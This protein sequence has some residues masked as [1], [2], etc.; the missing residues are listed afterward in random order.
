MGLTVFD[1]GVLIGFLDRR[2]GHHVEAR[3]AL[4][5]AVERGDRLV[6]PASAYAETI[7]APSRKGVEAVDTVRQLIDRTPIDVV[8]LDRDIAEA[9]ATFRAQHAGLKLPDALVIATAAILDADEL[10][11][12]DRRWPS[13]ANLGLS[14]DITVL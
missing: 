13:R 2:D 1:A 14:A 10:V 9:G 6:L 3:Q 7:V 8:P 12:T 4:A 5:D 11:T